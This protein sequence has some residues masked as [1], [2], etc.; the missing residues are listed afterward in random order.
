MRVAFKPEALFKKSAAAPKKA[1]K[2]AKKA[3][4]KI[5]PG[6]KTT[7]GWLGGAGGAQGLD[8]WYG[9]FAHPQKCLPFPSPAIVSEQ[10][11]IQT[12][13][14]LQQDLP[15]VPAQ[16]TALCYKLL[17]LQPESR[18][19][20]ATHAGPNR[21]TAWSA[22]SKVSLETGMQQLAQIPF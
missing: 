17:P 7:R 21:P 3:V 10:S 15:R 2:A 18:K 22:I 11:S 9:E 5:T 13:L 19:L 1:A 12:T 8:K 14:T 16:S 6:S 20:V 4:A